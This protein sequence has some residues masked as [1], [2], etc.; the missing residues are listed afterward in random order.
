M[1][2]ERS[3]FL[4]KIASIRGDQRRLRQISRRIMNSTVGAGK[5]QLIQNMRSI[6]QLFEVRIVVYNDKMEI[7]G[8]FPTQTLGVLRAR[9]RQL[10]N[11]GVG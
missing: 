9:G 8:H 1:H 7:Q 2:W 11:Q 6:L 10:I 5:M 3:D 4:E